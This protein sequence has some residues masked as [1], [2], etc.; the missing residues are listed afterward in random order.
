MCFVAGCSSVEVANGQVL[1]C[2]YKSSDLAWEMQGYSFSAKVYIIPLESYHLILGG[3][4]LLTLEEIRWNFDKLSMNFMLKEIKVTLI[5]ES[6]LVKKETC[7]A[8]SESE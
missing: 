8:Y 3:Q 7:P 4:W 6:C 5:G 2:T 1:Q